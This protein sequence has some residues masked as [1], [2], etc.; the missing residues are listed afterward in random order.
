MTKSRLNLKKN[1]NLLSGLHYMQFKLSIS[2]SRR[3]TRRKFI[4]VDSFLLT[5]YFMVPYRPFLRR[6][7]LTLFLGKRRNKGWRKGVAFI[8][9][10][11]VMKN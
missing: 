7:L 3:K 4:P 5:G 1:R 9:G 8:Y 2:R 10:R 6:P 11:A